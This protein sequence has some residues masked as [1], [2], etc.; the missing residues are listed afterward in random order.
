MNVVEEVFVVSE[1]DYLA[2]SRPD[3]VFFVRGVDGKLYRHMK[4]MDGREVLMP[5]PTSLEVETSKL[6]FDIR[7]FIP[8]KIPGALLEQTVA[9]FRAVMHKPETRNAEAFVQ[10][11]AKKNELG[12]EYFLV[13]PKQT[14]SQGSAKA[15]I[16]PSH[17]ASLY[18]E[19]CVPIGDIHSHNTMGAFFSS[20]DDADDAKKIGIAGVVGNITQNG[21]S[22]SWR[23]CCGENKTITLK[24]SDI[25][26]DLHETTFPKE[27]LE[28]V[29]GGYSHSSGYRKYPESK[30]YGPDGFWQAQS[31]EDWG[32]DPVASLANEAA[33]EWMGKG[34]PALGAG[35]NLSKS[36]KRAVEL[37]GTFGGTGRKG[38]IVR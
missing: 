23:F 36:Q 4:F 6:Q 9:F 26:E 38:G 13:V 14:V 35:N 3:S 37:R 7:A 29:S 22:S 18:A 16:D 34:I 12:L 8:A 28:Q 11:W 31:G 33:G 21:Y 20:T 32:L 19:G 15:D 1:E 24:V 30:Q 2:G 17:T 10:V 27:W 5:S 25:F